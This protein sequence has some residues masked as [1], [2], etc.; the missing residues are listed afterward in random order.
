[1]GITTCLPAARPMTVAPS[2]APN[3]PAQHGSASATNADDGRFL[4]QR[5]SELTTRCTHAQGS[6]TYPAR[7]CA[8]STA[9]WFPACLERA[10][11]GAHPFDWR[12]HDPALRLIRARPAS[13]IR[14]CAPP[15]AWVAEKG[16]DKVAVSGRVRHPETRCPA[17]KRLRP[18]A[19]EYIANTHVV[20]WRQVAGAVGE[21][22]SSRHR[23]AMPDTLETRGLDLMEGHPAEG[24][25][26]AHPRVDPAPRRT[27]HVHSGIKFGA[28]AAR[29]G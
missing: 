18:A 5:R 22:A 20:R 13:A 27:A 24:E 23:G 21:E 10:V 28:P 26:S 12:R 3:P 8:R 25:L 29:C 14:F 19:Q 15:R 11:A 1:M 6:G 7:A 9:K 17:A 16:A 2:A 4:P